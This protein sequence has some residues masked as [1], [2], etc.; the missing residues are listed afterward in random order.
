MDYLKLLEHSFI[1][2]YDGIGFI[3]YLN[4]GE[5]SMFITV[6]WEDTAYR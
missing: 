3:L 5:D 6:N 1:M 4:S 2:S